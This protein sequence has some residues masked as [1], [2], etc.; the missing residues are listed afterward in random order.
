[1][2]EKYLNLTVTTDNLGLVIPQILTKYGSGQA[3]SISGK[4]AK[5]WSGANFT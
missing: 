4:F 3:V 2:L 1:L 5:T